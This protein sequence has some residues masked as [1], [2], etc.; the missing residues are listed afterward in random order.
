MADA[1]MKYET[2]DKDQINDLM[3]R[4]PV[5]DPEGWDDSTPPNKSIKTDSTVDKKDD[6]DKS[7][8]SAAEQN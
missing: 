8:G 7:I 6:A 5:R 4:K 3:A 1:L 2:I